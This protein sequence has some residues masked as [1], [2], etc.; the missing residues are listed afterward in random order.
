MIPILQPE[1]H[2][3]D[4][5]RRLSWLTLLAAAYLGFAAVTHDHPTVIFCPFRLLTKQPCPLCGFTTATGQAIH[6]DFRAAQQSH[7]LIFPVIIA[8]GFWYFRSIG[9]LLHA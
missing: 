3:R 9:K 6:G 7:P 8:A 2:P 5:A 1:M 4:R